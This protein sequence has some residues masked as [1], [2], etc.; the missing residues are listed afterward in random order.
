M[1]E[2]LS[3]Q[4]I[5]I[6]AAVIALLANML[7]VAREY[8]R[9]VVF[10][11][12]RFVGA[13]GPGLVFLIPFID[14]IQKVDLRIHT[15]DIPSQDVITKDNVSVTVNAVVYRRI[16]DAKAS[17]L[18]VEDVAFATSQ[19]AQ[20]AL[21]STLGRADLNALL[22]EQERLSADL[23][24]IIARQVEDW[25][26]AILSVEIKDVQL[27]ESMKRALARR[28]EAERERRAKVIHAQGELAAA[29]R[30]SE[31]AAVMSAQP[32]AMQLRYLQSITEV[33]AENNT[34][35]IIPLPTELSDLL[36]LLTGR[37][38][39]LAPNIEVARKADA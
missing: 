24:T 6:A 16:T 19:V 36:R 21:R 37:S 35:T 9:C 18:G 29:R 1:L 2:Y 17:V 27:P 32:T 20:T 13:K 22:T 34:T 7:R 4:N 28:A 11:L 26:V 10:R 33:A 39:N 38:E 14:R 5:V 12:G 8:E 3:A 25:G 15:D 31:S 23:Q 30:L